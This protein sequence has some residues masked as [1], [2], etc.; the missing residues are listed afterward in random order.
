[1]NRFF[2]NSTQIENNNIKILGDDIGHI[3]N[4]LRLKSKDRIEIVSEGRIYLCQIL[5]IRPNEVNTVIIQS[6]EGKNEAPIDIILYQSIAKGNKMD[7]IIQKAT[8]IGVKKIYP[9]I[10]ERTVVKIKD[11]KKEQNKVRRWNLIAQEAAKQSKRD[12]LPVIENIISFNEMLGILR[13]EKNIILPYEGEKSSGLKEVLTNLDEGNIHIIIGPEGGFEL[14]E[15][16][17]IKDIKGQVVSLGPRILRTE[18]AGIVAISIVLY[19]LGDL[20][21]I[22]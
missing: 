3:K 8:E 20:G 9:V 16:L 5:D 15:V 17:K 22:V 6:E 7:F 11:F 4:V 12:I 14:K 13:D 19:E 1:M 10:T 18:T 2:V 21:V